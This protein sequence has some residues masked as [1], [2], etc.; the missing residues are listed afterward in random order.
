[1]PIT[2]QENKQLAELFLHI[3]FNDWE[4]V[5][6]FKTE[7]PNIFANKS[8]FLIDGKTPFNLIYL[9]HF[10]VII[11]N[12][13]E[14]RQEAMPFVLDM[15]NKTQSMIAFWQAEGEWEQLPKFQYN[16]YHEYFV[17]ANPDDLEERFEIV[18]TPLAEVIK[19]GFREIDAT[20]FASVQCFDF[21][22]AE[23]LLKLGAKSNIAFETSE[24]TTI[25]LVLTA[26]SYHA[27]CRVIPTFKYENKQTLIDTITDSEVQGLLEDLLAL[28]ANTEMYYLLK[29]YT[30]AIN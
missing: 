10:N 7:Y 9:T 23:H 15:R 27:T 14:W 3:Y 4:A 30:S 28:A 29:R 16:Y 21:D 24:D 22:D 19:K 13:D 11:W 6:Q 26:I 8:N 2:T 18:T 1:M 17:C 12:D 5:T 20:L 25:S